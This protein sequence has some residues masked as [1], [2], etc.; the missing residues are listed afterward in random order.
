MK[1]HYGEPSGDF[2]LILSKDEL[3][4]LESTGRLSIH[5]P[6][7][8]CDES[9]IVWNPVKKDMDVVDRRN[10]ES[11]GLVL[12][13]YIGGD[14]GS[15]KRYIQF[16]NICIED[17]RKDCSICQLHGYKLPTYS[18]DYTDGTQ[19]TGLAHF[20]PECGRYIGMLPRYSGIV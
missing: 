12:L 13:D 16:L 19:Y 9:R 2:T 14:I 10:I 8:P 4:R 1:S 6:E 18:L 3:H 20:C 11:A 5:T 7:I 17:E 15:E